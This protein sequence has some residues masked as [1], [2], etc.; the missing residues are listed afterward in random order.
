MSDGKQI[1]LK[2]HRRKYPR[3]ATW[4]I[5]F[6]SLL[7]E[8]GE[9][10]AFVKL[11]EYFL[12]DGHVCL[13]FEKHGR[14]LSEA[15]SRKPLTLTRTKQVARRILLGLSQLHAQ[16]YAHSDVKPENILYDARRGEARL[17]D[18]GSAT[19]RLKQCM[20]CG[21]RE[22]IAPELLLGAPVGVEIDLWS[23]GCTVFEMLTG[24]MLFAPR[25]VAAQKYKELSVEHLAIP[26]ADSVAKD[27][28]EELAE[29]YRKGALIAGKYLLKRKLGQGRFGS[30]WA[31]ETHH[32]RKVGGGH[33]EVWNHAAAVIES[34]PD[35][36]EQDKRDSL[37]R[38]EKGADDLIDLAINHEHTI[39]MQTLLGP[40]PAGLV[41]EARYRA[42]YF[43]ADGALR[44]RPEV[45][46]VSI[47]V[48]LRRETKLR[49][50]E[51]DSTADFLSGLLQM[52]KAARIAAP[53]AL[54]HNWLAR[55]ARR[56]LVTSDLP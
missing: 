38:K 7:G 34:R 56:L 24:R 30:V 13:S 42:S 15:L 8:P 10:P 33:V 45:K 19:N 50:A 26:M 49:G 17:A 48:R 11:D 46:S 2:I 40:F 51:L 25:R 27:H 37:W 39:L 55:T 1:A 28:E 53:D 3:A 36:T 44:F 16:G 6:H 18:L 35:A 41:Q 29:Q 23:L 47:R 5:Y 4:E 52:D 32:A 31:A 9:E 43:E 20:S 12:H 21:T 22:Y 54:K 14:S